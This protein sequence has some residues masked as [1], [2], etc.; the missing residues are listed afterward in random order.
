MLR[1]GLLLFPPYDF[2]RFGSGIRTMVKKVVRT[3][4]IHFFLADKL[5][6]VGDCVAWQDRG[7]AQL[8]VF[9]T[10]LLLPLSLLFGR[11]SAQTA[12]AELM[13]ESLL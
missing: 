8:Q 9:G 6:F 13:Q 3:A 10:K 2:N 4:Y 5:S 11:Q 12:G 7:D 1:E